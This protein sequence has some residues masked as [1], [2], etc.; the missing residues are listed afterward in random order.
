M[1]TF[2]VKP[3]TIR[4][5]SEEIKKSFDNVVNSKELLG[6]VGDFS[7]E[8]IKYQARIG[9]PINETNDFKA[10]ESSSIRSRQYLA[11]HNETHDAYKDRR[12][13][14]TLT[15]KLLDSLRYSI[16]GPGLLEL[17][18]FGNHPGYK[19]GG[20]DTESESNSQIIKWLSKKGFVVFD[21]SLNTNNKFKS[22]IKTIVLRYLRRA[23]AVRRKLG[24]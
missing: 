15:G 10:L 13:N 18:F 19:T 23:I 22:R 5:V 16:K 24:T 9:K 14:L 3:E 21:K 4:A 6:E 7:V 20:K 17:F 11:K 2:K 1:F 8:R 12:S